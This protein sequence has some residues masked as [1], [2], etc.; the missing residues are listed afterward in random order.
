MGASGH[1]QNYQVTE[2]KPSQNLKTFAVGAVAIG[3]ISFAIGLLQAPE[4]TWAAYLTA[5]MFVAGLSLGGFFFVAINN[6][7]KAGWS[8]SIRRLAEG[9]TSFLPVM[10]LASLVL[11]AGVKY[12]YPWADAEYRAAHSLVEAK[13]GYLNVGF[14]TVRLLVFGLLMVFFAR[15]IVGNSLAQDKSG[16]VALTHDNVKW[17]VI[18]TPLFAI[19]FTLFSMDLLMSL[20]PTWYSTIFGIYLFSGAFQSALALIL[21]IMIFMKNSG[22]ITGYY[23][24]DHVHDVAKYLKGFS[25]FWAYIAFSQFMLIWYANI[26]EETEFYLMRA[27]G[28]WMALS[29]ALLVFKFIVPFIALLPRSFK[30]N[31]GHVAAVALLVILTQYLDVYW[32][33]Y[34]NFNDHVPKFGFYEIGLLLGFLGLF[35]LCLIRFYKSNS[36][37]AIKDPRMHEALNHHVTY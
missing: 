24:D 21:L 11:L 3:V 31:E 9:L 1:S 33:V 2:F 13:T 19:S 26:P 29:F 17:S 34:P 8:V 35:L 18:W 22:F 12:L 27:H 28:G 4:R 10:L 23:G 7:T 6:L 5:F 30:R 20:L 14:L 36:L 25:I 16:D 32:L 15:K 37:V